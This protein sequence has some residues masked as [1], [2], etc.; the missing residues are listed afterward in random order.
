MNKIGGSVRVRNELTSA[1]AEGRSVT[2]KVRWVFKADEE[3]R[4]RWIHCTPLL[5]SN[6]RIGVWMV[7]LVDEEQEVSR[8]WRRA[9]PVDSNLGQSVRTQRNE[10]D[11]SVSNG[12]YFPHSRGSRSSS[13]RGSKEMGGAD[14]VS[15]HGSSIRSSSPYHL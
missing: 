3:G 5:G 11:Q 13:T 1:L 8:R 15:L 14:S 2:A 12:E 7:V 9:P 10:R 4:N 6:G